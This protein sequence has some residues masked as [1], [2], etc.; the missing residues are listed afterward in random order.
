VGIPTTTILRRRGDLVEDIR[1][2]IDLA[3]LFAPAAPEQQ[4][5]AAAAS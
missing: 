5:A 3:P 4:P 1:I 2:Y